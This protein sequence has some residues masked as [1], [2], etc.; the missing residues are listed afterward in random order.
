MAHRRRWAT[1]TPGGHSGGS[2]SMLLRDS[3]DAKQGLPGPLGPSMKRHQRCKS[4]LSSVSEDMVYKF[5]ARARVGVAQRRA[6]A[7]AVP[8]PRVEPAW[9]CRAVTVD[10]VDACRPHASATVPTATV[11]PVDHDHR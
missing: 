4:C 2:G 10:P 5:T 6:H 1:V 9:T 8:R 11:T 3:D 7:Q